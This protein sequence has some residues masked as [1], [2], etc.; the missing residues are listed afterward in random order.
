MV[1]CAA[2]YRREAALARLTT[3][4]GAKR[5]IIFGLPRHQVRPIRL[6]YQ[7]AP[8]L[9]APA[10]KRLQAF[11]FYSTENIPHYFIIRQNMPVHHS[12]EVTVLK[13][14]LKALTAQHKRL[15]IPGICR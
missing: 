2:G 5:R 11:L 6:I 7:P 13:R 12:R 8:N 14:K 15:L 1:A 4:K 3:P 10:V 9:I